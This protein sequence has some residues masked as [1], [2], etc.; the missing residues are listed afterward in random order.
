MLCGAFGGVFWNLTGRYGV[1]LCVRYLLVTL[2]I[3]TSH[4]M[5][6]ESHLSGSKVVNLATL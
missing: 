3:E 4:Q 2:Y 1:R 5:Y 6:S